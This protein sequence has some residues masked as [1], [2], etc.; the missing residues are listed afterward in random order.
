MKTVHFRE[1]SQSDQSLCLF[2]APE[3]E[4]RLALSYTAAGHI[5][6]QRNVIRT[7]DTYQSLHPLSRVSRSER[8]WRTYIHLMHQL[9]HLQASPVRESGST[10]LKAKILD[11]SI[12]IKH[13]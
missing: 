4:G 1:G 6:R 2:L 10:T 5:A 13:G 3:R 11:L 9:Y 12:A 8:E 7:W